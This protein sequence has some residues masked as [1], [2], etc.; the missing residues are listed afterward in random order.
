MW[1]RG[2]ACWLQNGSA[3]RFAP[4]PPQGFKT[5]CSFLYHFKSCPV[6]STEQ[7]LNR[8]HAGSFK[9]RQQITSGGFER[10]PSRSTSAFQ[11]VL[12]PGTPASG[13]S[14]VRPPARRVGLGALRD[15]L[16]ARA[17]DVDRVDLIRPAPIRD[18]CDL[19]AVRRPG[20]E[21]VVER[22][23]VIMRQLAKTRAVDSDRVD[24]RERGR[25]KAALNATRVPSGE[26]SILSASVC[27]G[28]M[29]LRPPLPAP[30]WATK[31]AALPSRGRGS[32][33]RPPASH[34][35]RHT[36]CPRNRECRRPGVAFLRRKRSSSG[37][38]SGRACASI[39]KPA[40]PAA[41]A[42]IERVQS[43]AI[44]SHGVELRLVRAPLPDEADRLAV[45]RPGRVRRVAV[46]ER[47]ERAAPLP[48]G[49]T[50]NNWTCAPTCA[51]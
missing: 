8:V 20:V 33:G 37:G 21:A 39:R 3:G 46:R 2:R 24:V 30:I 13:G 28:V 7:D 50:V 34:P 4:R 1:W 27:H 40:G 42:S 26:Q 19:L 48:S 17:V 41:E 18:E 29:R 36:G 5:C 31:I 12:H 22:A 10:T 35:A 51:W 11:H 14:R 49:R 44:G 43:T 25:P 16:Q 6:R 45:R 9:K 23:A 15:L 38:V 32:Q 47:R